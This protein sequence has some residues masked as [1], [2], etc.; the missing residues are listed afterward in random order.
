MV[1]GDAEKHRGG[2]G[3]GAAAHLPVLQGLFIDAKQVCEQ[4]LR[5]AE[6]VTDLDDLGWGVESGGMRR[7]GFATTDG[8]HLADTLQQFLGK[9]F[10]QDDS[11]NRHW[12]KLELFGGSYYN[13][14]FD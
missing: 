11:S 8:F 3:E 6:L 14:R 13:A 9:C 1:G 2:A 4:R 5:D 12:A 7:L 10:F